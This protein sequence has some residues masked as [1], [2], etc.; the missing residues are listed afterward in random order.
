MTKVVVHSVVVWLIE[1]A[2]IKYSIPC[3]PGNSLNPSQEPTLKM[4]KHKPST[5]D[6]TEAQS[7]KRPLSHADRLKLLY[8]VFQL[9]F[10]SWCLKTTTTNSIWFIQQRVGGTTLLFC[11]AYFLMLLHRWWCFYACQYAS[12]CVC[13]G[14]GGGAIKAHSDWLF[15]FFPS[16]VRCVAEAAGDAVG[17]GV[18]GETDGDSWEARLGGAH[19][20][21]V[22][23]GEA[24]AWI[25]ARP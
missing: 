10:S 9:S 25:R 18:R 16:H 14:G 5:W 13:V 3:F 17:A 2:W 8:K 11:S 15:I 21:A 4:E 6:F 23:P 19:R 24:P 1:G 7:L 22:W 12:C 20:N